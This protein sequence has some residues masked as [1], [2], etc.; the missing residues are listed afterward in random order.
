MAKCIYRYLHVY[1]QAGTC[2]RVCTH[3]NFGCATPKIIVGTNPDCGYKTMV[4]IIVHFIQYIHTVCE[5]NGIQ[6]LYAIP[7]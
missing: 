4:V 6:K 5:A 1:V 7:K 3:N 2:I